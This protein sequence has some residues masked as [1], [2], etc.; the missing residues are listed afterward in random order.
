MRRLERNTAGLRKARR[1]AMAWIA[2]ALLIV[3]TAC[4]SL[5]E[6]E[7]PGQ[8]LDEALND[9]ALAN[10]LLVSALGEFECAYNQL[11]P[12]NAFLTGEFIASNFFRGSNLWGWRS[13]A[14]L[15]AD[16]GA[17]PTARD[18]SNYGYYTP[19]QRARFMAEDG[20]RRISN[21]SET[22][23]PQKTTMLATLTAYA[24]YSYL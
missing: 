3:A 18:A 17:C 13:Q 20:A 24:G 23:V 15:R 8:V 9:P 14:D 7:L 16:D 1:I 19:L 4:E 6:V 22:Q 21:L 10:T 2:G 12:T 11:V 5:M